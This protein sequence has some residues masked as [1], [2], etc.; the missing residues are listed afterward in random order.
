M[1][2]PWGFSSQHGLKAQTHVLEDA[3]GTL[4]TEDSWGKAT[5]GLEHVILERTLWREFL[6]IW[7]SHW[8]ILWFPSHRD[9][10]FGNSSLAVMP[11]TLALCLP[12]LFVMT[13]HP[14]K[15]VTLRNP[16]F[17]SFKNFLQFIRFFLSAFLNWR[18]IKIQ[19]Y[20]SFRC[21]T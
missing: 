1:S 16:C 13:T 10:I 2:W 20:V 8:F 21:A 17:K 6:K 4:L 5:G 19:R 15:T 11:N 3:S 12:L 7:I 9:F 14:R 18:I